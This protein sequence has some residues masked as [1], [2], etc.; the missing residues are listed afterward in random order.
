MAVGKI[1]ILE[2]V[3][4]QPKQAQA[5]DIAYI[6]LL[7]TAAAG[8]MQIGGNNVTQIDV[9]GGT[10]VT[11]V[12]VG[13]GTAVA[14]MSIGTGAALAVLGIGTGMGAG[15]AISVGANAL[16]TLNLSGL[17]INIGNA[18]NTAAVDIKGN[19]TVQGTET[20]IG[21][22]QFDDDAVFKGD[23]TFGDGL[24]VPP[25]HDTVTFAAGTEVTSNIVFGGA[26]RTIDGGVP[27]AGGAGYDLT[28]KSGT[29]TGAGPSN[30]G[31]CTL[32]G[33]DGVGTTSNGGL[34]TV[35]GGAGGATGNG[36]NVQLDGGSGGAVGSVLVGTNG[37][38]TARVDLGASGSGKAAVEITNTG[39]NTATVVLGAA[40]LWDDTVPAG[41]VKL[42][43]GKSTDAEFPIYANLPGANPPGIRYDTVS[44]KWQVQTSSVT[45]QPLT[46]G[47]AVLPTGSEK[48]VLQWLSGSAT[49]SDNIH[50]PNTGT[51]P[52]T[53]DVAAP[54]ASGA[55]QNLTMAAGAALTSGAGG[56][57]ILNG[58]AQAGVV[59]NLAGNV[60]IGATNT[61]LVTLGSLTNGW[62][63]DVTG[64]MLEYIPAGSGNIRLPTQF[65]IAA[66]QASAN[67]TA[68]NLNTLTA[69]TSSNADALHTHNGVGGFTKLA[70][71]AL[72]AGNPL[73]AYNDAGTA[74]VTQADAS[75]AATHFTV[76]FAT[77]IV[78]G[79]GS[80]P[81]QTN[82]TIVIPAGLWDGG[83]PAA[84]D[85]GKPL[86]NSPTTA[87]NVTITP[88][89]TSGKFIQKL[90]VVL[91]DAG[92]ILI[93]IGDVITL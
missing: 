73:A 17:A 24:P 18:A 68:T 86:Y 70:F 50:L 88:Y 90:G 56:N 40:G 93:Q 53:I 79:G 64:N 82:G 29:A 15:D 42:L 61:T 36:G 2:S 12:N 19:L 28:V 63:L 41:N 26:A 20:V 5:A 84:A 65:Y 7:D 14:A 71:I 60:Q 22:S 74:K 37:T 4:G 69:G 44:S 77:A 78:S 76:G 55:G 32:L 80:E 81:V 46:A 59:T 51:L 75:G 16:A 33:G 48:Q 83:T 34:I 30:G 92:T 10:G 21:T 25:A 8:T 43:I 27:A 57:L 49:W 66:V 35:R 85:I 89:I 1:L 58:G 72:T 38:G 6:N 9:A 23:V 45:W 11:T 67:V 52:R 54:G 62:R 87:G 39:A 31:R 91:D 47:G 3:S 13:N